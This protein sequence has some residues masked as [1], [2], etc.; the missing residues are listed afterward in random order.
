MGGDGKS[1]VKR[2]EEGSRVNQNFGEA[3][4]HHAP[5]SGERD[6]IMCSVVPCEGSVG[7]WRLRGH[8]L[9]CSA[10]GAVWVFWVTDQLKIEPTEFRS[11]LTNE[12]V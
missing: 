5:G 6:Q 10:N 3:P 12:G 1:T 8:T 11:S 9:F 2:Q 7:L 4:P